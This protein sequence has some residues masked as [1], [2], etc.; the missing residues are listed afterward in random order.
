MSLLIY[1]VKGILFY[2]NTH[3]GENL[4]EFNKN[5]RATLQNE[6]N[7]GNHSCFECLKDKL[8]I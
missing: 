8:D 6:C 5:Q 2:T 1:I 4:I 3:Y 7:R